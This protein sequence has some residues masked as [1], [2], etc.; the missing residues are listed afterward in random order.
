MINV[1]MPNG[2]ILA[3]ANK[4]VARGY[5]NYGGGEV[6]TDEPKEPPKA[7]RGRKPKEPVSGSSE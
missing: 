4:A 3:T 1:K 6:V 2:T 5:I 7:R